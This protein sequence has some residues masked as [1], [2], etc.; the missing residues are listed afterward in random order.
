M[1]FTGKARWAAMLLLAI[2]V[3][4][5]SPI[6]AADDFYFGVHNDYGLRRSPA[7]VLVADLTDCHGGR[8]SYSEFNS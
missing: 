2:A 1:I 5:I 7:Q 4:G 6:T 3:H 8:S